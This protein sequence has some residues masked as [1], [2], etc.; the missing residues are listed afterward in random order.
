MIYIFWALF[1]KIYS[2]TYFK[3][4]K[5]LK[6]FGLNVTKCSYFTEYFLSIY[7]LLKEVMAVCHWISIIIFYSALYH[8]KKTVVII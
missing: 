8:T 1:E 7:L 5:S 3:L 4:Q 2:S 6:D